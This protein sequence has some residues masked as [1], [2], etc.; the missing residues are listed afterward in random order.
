MLI[1]VGVDFCGTYCILRAFKS[2]LPCGGGLGVG[3]FVIASKSQDLRVAIYKIKKEINCHATAN[4]FARNDGVVDCHENPCG[5]SRNDEKYCYLKRYDNI[6][7][8]S[9]IFVA[10]V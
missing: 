2:P 1:V 8:L 4:A 10:I 7:N 3:F 5:F 9:R 6:K